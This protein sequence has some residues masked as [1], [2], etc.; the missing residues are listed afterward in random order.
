M[1]LSTGSIEAN[2]VFRAHTSLVFGRIEGRRWRV[3]RLFGPSMPRHAQLQA[4]D[5]PSL[6]KTVAVAALLDSKLYVR[7]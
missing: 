7:E 4:V 3:I 1:T 6:I 2:I 5:E